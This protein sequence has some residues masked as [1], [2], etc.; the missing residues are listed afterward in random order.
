MGVSKL[1]LTGI[2]DSKLTTVLIPMRSR[3]CGY[4]FRHHQ[5]VCKQDIWIS[6]FYLIVIILF[7]VDENIA[8]GTYTWLDNFMY[9]FDTYHIG[10]QVFFYQW[11]PCHFTVIRDG[12]HGLLYFIICSWV[13][14]FMSSIDGVSACTTHEVYQKVFQH[15]PLFERIC[16]IISEI[17][18]QAQ[19]N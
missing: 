5:E 2:L 3:H 13:F 17:I 12:V 7:I 10:H 19:I 14:I 11:M 4:C 6:M 8:F 1:V 9:L 18:Y 16:I 15:N